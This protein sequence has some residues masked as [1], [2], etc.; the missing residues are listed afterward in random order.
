MEVTIFRGTEH[1]SMAAIETAAQTA[2]S[3]TNALPAQDTQ[4]PPVNAD[5]LTRAIAPWQHHGRRQMLVK[6][7]LLLLDVAVF[8]GCFLISRG[9]LWAYRDIDLTSELDQWWESTGVIR[10]QVFALVV[11]VAIVWLG[12][13]CGHYTPSRRRPWWD[14]IR[15]LATVIALAAMADTTLMY[16][17]KW[18][19]SRLATGITWTM[20][21]VAA[22]LARLM[23]QRWLARQGWLAQPYV[24]VG[25]PAAAQEAAAA[26]ASEPLMGYQPVALVSPG[27]QMQA[28]VSLPGCEL[29]P[30][31]YNSQV[32]QY[33]TRPGPYQVVIALDNR[34]DLWLR[35][36][37]QDLMLTRDDVVLVPPLSGLP[38]LGMETSH[39]FSHDVLLLR[40]RNNLQRRGPQLLKRAFDIVVSILLLIVLSP[41]MLWVA[42]RI[43]REDGGPVLYI[44]PRVGK[45]GHPFPFF[46]FRSMVLDADAALQ[47]WKESHPE[48]YEQYRANNFKLAEDPRVTRVGRWIRRTSI[49]ELPQLINVL[50]GEM[51]LVGPRPLLERELPD[52]GPGIGTYQMTRP[53]ITGLWQINGRSTTTF[54]Q[55]IAMDLWY[56]R[57]WSLWYDFVILVRTVRVV[58][59][60]EGA[61]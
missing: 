14:E 41:L 32:R 21:M 36:L 56:V 45:N 12:S 3:E 29:H 2:S 35:S 48:L 9:L 42:W 28:T 19:F 59:K 53:G 4:P 30:V 1:F 15:Q 18:Q 57:N 31:A 40:A 6:C 33:L 23:V 55:R 34:N 51:S 58:L 50:R 20:I 27:H 37:A 44:H 8:W 46:K 22:P 47:R 24:L 26:L 7:L 10:T 61:V 60:Q 38:L 43:R 16:L 5:A 49:D 39:F 17:G 25:A 11:A 52:Y 54:A 13:V